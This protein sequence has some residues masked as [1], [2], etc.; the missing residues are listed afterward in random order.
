[1]ETKNWEEAKRI[2]GAAIKYAAPDRARFLDEV[3]NDDANLR[4][5]VESLLVSF[6]E[7]ESFMET[8][9]IG[10]MAGALDGNN[11][12]LERGVCF[13]H[14]EVIELVGVGGMGEVYLAKDKR[15]GRRVAVKIL[16]EKFAKNESNLK[17]FTQEA[18]AA[19][20]LNHPNILI[21]HE[22]GEE[23]ATNYIVSEFIEGKT[24]R[25]IFESSP[26][27]LSEALDM[28]IQ[29]A[30][31][32]TA[33]HVAAIVHRDIK[34]ENIMV[35]PD[36]YVKVLDFGLAKLVEQKPIGLEDETAR[37]NQTAEGM[38]LGTVNYMSPEQAKGDR[39]DGRT[40]IFSFGV[41]LYEMIAGRTP[42][43]GNSMSETFANLINS[44]PQ[45]LSRFAANVP[46]ELERIVSKTLRKDREE[47]YQ[48]MKGLL[49]D[50][51]DLRENLAF[52]ERLERS[53]SGSGKN[54]TAGLRTETLNANERSAQTEY[55]FTGQRKGGKFLASVA[56]AFLLIAIGTVGF[57]FWYQKSAGISNTAKRSL[58][59]LP[60]VNGSQDPNA[61]YLSDGITESIINN[62]SQL[63]GLKV[64]SRNSAFRFKDNQVDTRAIASQLGVEALVTGDIRQMGDNF[65]INVRLID[66]RDE[67][68]I[69][70]NQYIRSS[71][72]VIAAQNEISRAVA[73]NLRIKLTESDAQLLSKRPTDNPEAWQLY[74]RGRFHVFKLIP[75][76]VQKGIGYFQ[77]AIRVDPSYALAY[78]GLSDAYRTLAIGSEVSPIENLALSK[79]LSNRAIE[80]DESLSEGHSGLGMTV[81]WGDW[82]WK[83]SEDRYRRALELNPNNAMAHLYYAHLLATLGRHAETAAEMK[84][85]RELDPLFPFGNALEGQFLIY[86]GRTDD[87]LRQLHETVE[88]APGFWMP[89]LFASMAYIEKGMFEEAISSARRATELSPAQ[90]VSIANESYALAKSG[91]KEEAQMNLD[92]LLLLSTERF[93]PP[94][95]IAMIYNGLGEHEKAL[96]WLEKGFEQR[97]PKMVFLKV[98]PKWNNLRAEPRFIELMRRM[99]YE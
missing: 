3:C 85:A 35:R 79:T 27:K 75:P 33:A 42:F 89:H 37:Q 70:G 95:H 50:L 81:Y 28:A 36:G 6:D 68:Q 46:D 9:V 84:L 8:P 40:D 10:G 86:A 23:Q 11:K 77:Q 2:F 15:L 22:I 71:A 48:T 19:S 45:P 64:L 99:N 93:V 26:L 96:E 30:G 16:N 69:W 31:A 65:I 90:T 49:A 13:G 32:L 20:A 21:I 55:S 92:K 51:K 17:R 5:E 57:Y 53:N 12:K 24:L 54:V 59:V 18:K 62:L 67:T 63:S 52:D 83:E 43:A 87:A 38:I 1:M 7:S 97:D 73:Q 4:R 88:L 60:F 39:I 66:G 29:I 44:E 41:L 56:A 58:A 91:K 14:Y 94:G 74:Q 34:P 72:D 82:N 25:E 80:L 76:E 61:E 47:R 78:S 98:D